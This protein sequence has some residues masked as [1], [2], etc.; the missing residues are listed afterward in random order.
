MSMPNA[1]TFIGHL[2]EL[3]KRIILVLVV[4]LMAMIAG[5]FIAPQI[6]HYLKSRPPASDMV[7]NVFSPWDSAK[8]YMSV[9]LA[10]SI[11]V[12]LPYI[13]Y[14]IWAFVKKGLEPVEQNAAFMYIPFA[15]ISFIIGLCFSYFIVFPMSLAFTT[16]IAKNLGFS[17]T[18]GVS[19]YFSFMFSIII[20]VSLAF[21]L[22]IIVM[23]LTKLG[24]LN[25]KR[26][27]ALR[28]HAYLILVITASLISPP[29]IISHLMVFIPL[30]LL[31]EISIMLSKVVYRR[32]NQE[33]F[34]SG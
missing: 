22:P 13:L 33:A 26:L 16:S 24:V 11:V 2:G 20:P 3:R 19:Q 21:E 29:E 4:L 9:A 28:R 8:I 27:N 6:L 12:T 5:L 1:M 18:Y 25:P 30:V 34:T 15:L 31:Y 32:K 10:F 17:E 23:F 14:Q 7:W